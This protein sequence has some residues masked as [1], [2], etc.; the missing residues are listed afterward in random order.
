MSGGCWKCP[1]RR[2]TGSPT[3][4]TTSQALESEEDLRQQRREDEQVAELI[5]TSMKIEGLFRHAST[6]AA[7]LVIGD[8]PLDQLVPLYRDPRSPMPVTQFNM[9]WVEE[10]GLVKFDFL[11]LKTL[12]VLHR[13]VSFLA[14]RGVDVDLAQ[15]PLDDEKTFEM[16]SAGDTVGVFQL[17]SA[18]MRDV[19]K[20]LKPDR[21]RTSSWSPLPPKP[22]ETSTLC[23]NTTL[24]VTYM[25]LALEPVAGVPYRR[26][27]RTVSR[28]RELAGYTLGGADRRAMGKK[29]KAA[30]EN[31]ARP[32][33]RVKRHRRVLRRV[34]TDAACGYGFNKS[35]AAAYAL[36]SYQTAW[37]KA[38]Y[39]EEFLAASMALDAGSTDKLA[40]F[41]QECQRSE[42]PVL[43]P[44]VNH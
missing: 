12:T 13:A 39:P 8:R 21:L 28:P 20:G 30:M 6:H 7:G 40:V 42:I 16:L 31:S 3:S 5:D 44:D 17:E 19:L 11:G 26:F 10:A 18:G 27:I 22:M 14:A 35:H 2:L 1:I 41:R 34:R 32:S 37:L 23:G 15:L 43:A 36:V 4:P 33:S 29:I 9:K 38:N 25:H 24:H